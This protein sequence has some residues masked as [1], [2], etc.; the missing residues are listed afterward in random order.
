MRD[1]LVTPYWL[2]GF[3]LMALTATTFA[4]PRARRLRGA[5][6]AVLLL[7]WIVA[8]PMTASWALGTLQR[9]AAAEAA[10]CAPPAPHAWFIVLAGGLDARP[11]S[12]QDVEALSAPSLRRIIAAAQLAR[13]VPDS[14]LL[15]SGGMG[16]RW[17]EAD[18]MGSLAQLLGI[19]PQRIE[20][21]RES[22]NTLQNAREVAGMLR[23]AP[24]RQLYLLTSAYHMPRAWMS[25]RRSGLKVCALPVDFESLP[26]DSLRDLLPDDA[27]LGRMSHALHEY[28]GIAYYRLLK[29]R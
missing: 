18:L 19:A 28:L 27:A 13:D 14:H 20:L 23:D 6:A 10:E 25:F 17:K 9:T 4:E 7:W 22:R 26:H 5:C 3:A 8:T 21:E 29:F 12:A 24:P 2:L 1:L 11:R 16:R 15:I